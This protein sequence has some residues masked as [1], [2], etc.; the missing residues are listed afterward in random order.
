MPA[1]TDGTSVCEPARVVCAPAPTLGIT[2]AADL[3]KLTRFSLWPLPN[4]GPGSLRGILAVRGEVEFTITMPASLNC[5]CPAC[6]R[7]VI[8]RK[9]YL[10]PVKRLCRHCLAVVAGVIQ[11]LTVPNEAAVHAYNSTLVCH[12]LVNLVGVLSCQDDHHICIALH[13]HQD[14]GDRRTA[15]AVALVAA[16]A[17]VLVSCTPGLQQQ[18]SSFNKV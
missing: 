15:A 9:I 16:F 4:R 1:P 3:P 13:P 5:L 17:I 14:V 12:Q 7:L 10:L 6:E 2:Q 18:L 11:N 8:Q